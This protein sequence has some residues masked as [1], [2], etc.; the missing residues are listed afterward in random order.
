M[1]KETR[2]IRKIV[3][4]E[5]EN[6]QRMVKLIETRIEGDN[7]HNSDICA[8]LIYLSGKSVLEQENPE[9]SN[10]WIIKNCLFNFSTGSNGFA[11]NLIDPDNT[12]HGFSATFGIFESDESEAYEE[13]YDIVTEISKNYKINSKT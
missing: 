5:Y 3:H 11:V 2:E 7:A 13:L 1:K 6:I 4:D 9:W 12:I 10:A 8:K